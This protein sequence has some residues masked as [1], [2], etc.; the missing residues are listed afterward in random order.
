VLMGGSGE[1]GRPAGCCW[2]GAPRLPCCA[3]V[4]EGGRPSG[5]LGFMGSDAL[6]ELEACGLRLV[7]RC[8]PVGVVLPCG[9]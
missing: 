3:N 7:G 1:A 5:L 9:D 8:W 4:Y 6:L 2:F